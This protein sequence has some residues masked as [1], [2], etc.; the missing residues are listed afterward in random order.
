MHELGS[1][2]A[3]VNI[4]REESLNVNSTYLVASFHYINEEGMHVAPSGGC[5]DTTQ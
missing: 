4:I 3:H 1:G 2:A 5:D